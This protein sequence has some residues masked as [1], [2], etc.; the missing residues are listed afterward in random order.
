MKNYDITEK[1][2]FIDGTMVNTKP[3]KGLYT[4]DEKLFYYGTTKST[5]QVLPKELEDGSWKKYRAKHLLDK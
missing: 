2:S 4:Q 1:N 3:I 5:E